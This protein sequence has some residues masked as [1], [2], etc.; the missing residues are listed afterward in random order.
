MRSNPAGWLV[1]PLKNAGSRAAS[2]TGY[3][4][5]VR[6]VL[7]AAPVGVSFDL[8]GDVIIASGASIGGDLTAGSNAVVE[9]GTRIVGTAR[10][11]RNARVG[12]NSEL[13]GDVRLGPWTNLVASA[14]LVGEV[15]LG[16][17]CAVARRVTFQE[18]NHV[19]TKPG[20]QMR[21]YEECLDRTLP[22]E[23]DGPIEV[24][25]DVW[26]GADATVLSGVSIGDGAVIGANSVVTK[27]VDPYE[28]VA[29]V[30]ADHRG[31][32]FEETT[33]EALLDLAWWE[34]SD[35]RLREHADFFTRDV[36]AA[37][38]GLDLPE[39]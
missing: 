38:D 17:F 14:E 25:N 21:F 6:Y 32:R 3:P 4:G 15:E 16:G 35:E 20:I 22:H 2:L 8:D 27:D 11:D 26:F 37:L 12:P 23:S 24:G 9:K 5:P 29:G 13:R 28:I 33:R 39:A 30:P 10:L 34:W 1:E 36:A 18:Q 19:T 31:W 7:N